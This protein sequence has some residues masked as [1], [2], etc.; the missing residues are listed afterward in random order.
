M[1][2]GRGFLMKH[3][4]L[5]ILIFIAPLAHAMS[6]FHANPRGKAYALNR[7]MDD[8]DMQSVEGGVR[9]TVYLGEC[10][11]VRLF[12]HQEI[13]EFLADKHQ[14]DSKVAFWRREFTR[15]AAERGCL[16]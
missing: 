9:V 2:R 12:T 8:V 13:K 10:R 3:V 4:S 1:I 7:G 14:D 6:E 16:D 15:G 5:L 11:A